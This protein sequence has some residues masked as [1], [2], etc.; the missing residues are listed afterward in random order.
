[1]IK[2][3]E[4]TLIGVNFYPEDTA[5]GLYSTQMADY[6]EK[7]GHGINIIT[8]FP[9]YPQWSIR[10]EYCSKPKYLKEKKGNINILRYKQYVPIKPTFF[11]RVIHLL[12]FTFGSFFNIR[13]IKQTD[14]I[15][16]VVPFTSAIL[17]GWLLKRRTKAKLWVHI[18]DFEFDAALQT[19]GSNTVIK[20]VKKTVFNLLFAIEEYLFSKADVASTISYTMLEK[21]KTKSKGK[22]EYFPNW[23]DV[24]KINPKNHSIHPYLTSSKYKILYS[25][26][27]GEKQDWNLFMNMLDSF[28]NEEIEI[29]VVGD[30]AKKEWLVNRIK[31]YTF[32]KYFPPV[33]FDEL[34]DL[35]CSADLHILFQKQSVV[36]TVMPSKLLG[37]MAS[38]KPSL[39]TGNINSEVRKVLTESNGGIYKYD[40]SAESIVFEIKK[41]FKDRNAKSGIGCNARKYVVEKYAKDNILSKIEKKIGL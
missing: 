39:V 3:K 11:K 12:D 28:T 17:L 22:I 7:Q 18:Q 31:K 19:D 24:N 21:L 5:I 20:G 40:I 2:K 16:V 36:D 37:M 26:N 25:G 14:I 10:E 38:S 34:S 27:I 8:G 6:F 15:I 32:V 9:Y 41:L 4:I 30:G 1:M 29:V 33:P 13:K 23:V 35:L